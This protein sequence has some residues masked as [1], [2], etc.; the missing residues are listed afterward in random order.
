MFRSLIVREFDSSR[1][2]Q[3]KSSTVREFDS[4]G[5][6]QFESSTVQGF[7][8]LTVRQLDGSTVR[9][10]DGL[11]VFEGI[12]GYAIVRVLEPVRGRLE[13]RHSRVRVCS[14]VRVFR[15]LESSEYNMLTTCSS[16]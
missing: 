6:R 12:R 15:V 3:F 2:R 10:F 16:V 9:R 5:V 14:I 7:K 13:R 11:R 4:S 8:S 1:V